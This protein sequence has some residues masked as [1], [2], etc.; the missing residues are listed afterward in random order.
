MNLEYIK[1]TKRKFKIGDKIKI[2]PDHMQDHADVSF[3]RTYEIHHMRNGTIPYCFVDDAGD[4]HYCHDG[5]ISLASSN[6]VVTG[7]IDSKISEYQAK[8]RAID[9]ERADLVENIRKLEDALN[10]LS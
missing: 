8:I 3:N 7:L 4:D 5:E 9:L 6:D 2:K 10:I 1:L